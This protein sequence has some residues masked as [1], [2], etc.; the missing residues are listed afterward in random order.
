MTWVTLRRYM[1]P[2]HYANGWCNMSTGDYEWRWMLTVKFESGG[3]YSYMS[4][5]R[6]NCLNELECIYGEDAPAI[7]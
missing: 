1:V 7:A 5:S 6:V 4:P 2:T 3:V